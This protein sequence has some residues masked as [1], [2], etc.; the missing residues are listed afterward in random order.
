MG[1]IKVRSRRSGDSEMAQS[2]L[3]RLSLKLGVHTVEGQNQLLLPIVLCHSLA[4][5]RP[6]INF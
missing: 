5:P 6:G 3:E 4:C 1:I 2:G